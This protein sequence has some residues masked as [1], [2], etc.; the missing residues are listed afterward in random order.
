MS[1]HVVKHSTLNTRQQVGAFGYAVSG[2]CGAQGVAHGSKYYKWNNNWSTFE[3][4]TATLK[5][6]DRGGG[7]RGAQGQMKRI[8]SNI[9]SINFI[10]PSPSLPLMMRLRGPFGFWSSSS[11]FFGSWEPYPLHHHQC[12]Y[13]LLPQLCQLGVPSEVIRI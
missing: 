11:P 8:F 2:L 6:R 12:F 5:M 10:S 7:N 9:F 13:I 4:A 3:A 1:W